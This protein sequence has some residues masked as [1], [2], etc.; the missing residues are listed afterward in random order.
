MALSSS[1]VALEEAEPPPM[2]SETLSQAIKSFQSMDTN[3]DGVL[4]REEFRKG[5]GM[6][7]VDARFS[8]I[9]FNAF[10]RD[11]GGSVDQR[12]FAS[13][14]AVMMHP[15][16]PVQQLSLAFDGYGG[17]HFAWRLGEV[18]SWRRAFLTGTTPTRTGRSSS[19]SSR[20]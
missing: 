15:A 4:T 14:M 7:A 1:D 17:E 10:D 19:A 3:R 18:D 5:L 2:D 16:D 8:S 12:E 13:A 20:R 6:L 9:L 11:G